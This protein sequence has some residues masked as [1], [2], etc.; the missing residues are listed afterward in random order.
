MVRFP[1]AKSESGSY[2]FAPFTKEVNVNL[3][4]LDAFLT[5]GEIQSQLTVFY[6]SAYK[7]SCFAVFSVTLDNVGDNVDNPYVKLK[8]FPLDFDD[9]FMKVKTNL[10][11]D[12]KLFRHNSLYH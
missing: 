11:R 3:K 1:G 4:V 7:N 6:K 2:I 12:T 8:S 9:L 5:K 10:T